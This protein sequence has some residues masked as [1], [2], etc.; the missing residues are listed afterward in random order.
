MEKALHLGLSI[1]KFI[2]LIILVIVVNVLPMQFLLGGQQAPLFLEVLL[3]MGYL[4]VVFWI[5]RTLWKKYQSH[6]LEG[7]NC[8][9]FGWRDFGFA[10]LFFL[11]G[12]VLAILGTLLNFYLSGQEMSMNDAA[13]EMVGS[14]MNLSHPFFSLLYPV[15]LAVIAPII[16]EIVFRGFGNILFFKKQVSWLGAFVT[17][18]IFALLH[19]NSWTELPTYLVLGLVLYG[20]YARRGSLKDSIVVHFL[21]NL[22]SALLFLVSLFIG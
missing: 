22:P 17:T 21:N 4:L 9:R 18:L 2:G 13:L 12:R 3:V 19:V 5:L 15:T 1:I 7:V 10:L 11:A 6:L 20:A 16:E 8:L 14:Q